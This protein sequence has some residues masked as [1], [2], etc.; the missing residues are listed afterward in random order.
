MARRLPL[1]A[2]SHASDR[3]QAF[4]LLILGALFLVAAWI[5]HIVLG[6]PSTRYPLGVLLLGLG[7]LL[8]AALNPARLVSAALLTTA[9]GVPVFLF[10]KGLVPL[11]PTFTLYILAIGL[12]LLGIAWAARRS[13]VGKGAVTPAILV[14]LV[15]LVEYLLVT[16]HLPTQFVPFML[17]LW[18]PGLGLLLIGLAYLLSRR[19][20]PR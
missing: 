20:E 14:L 17:S 18:L 1:R 11:L 10:F 6:I 15:G 3:R 8:G 19:Q 2:S 4:A 7:M 13:Y 9:L 16:N 5:V 12:A